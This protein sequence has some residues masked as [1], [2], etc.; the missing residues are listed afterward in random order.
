MEQVRAFPSIMLQDRRAFDRSLF[1]RACA[2]RKLRVTGP[3][4][5]VASVLEQS[6]DHPNVDEIHARAVKLVPGIST[7]TVYRT[8]KL[9]TDLNLIVRHRFTDGPARFELMTLQQHD[10]LIDLESGRVLE[11]RDTRLDAIQAD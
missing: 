5:A 11:F 8:L 2:E 10:H 9:F 4:L 6:N 7:A 3:R 1:Y